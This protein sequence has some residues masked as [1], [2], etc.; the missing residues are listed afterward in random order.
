MIMPPSLLKM[1]RPSPQRHKWTHSRPVTPLLSLDLIR[2]VSDARY[3][4][5][6]LWLRFS[7]R[8]RVIAPQGQ[9]SGLGFLVAKGILVRKGESRG[10]NRRLGHSPSDRRLGSNPAM[11]DKRAAA[12]AMP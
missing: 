5:V 10:P 4:A 8:A 9:R 3:A 12:C 2:K 6:H 1:W 7:A 11:T